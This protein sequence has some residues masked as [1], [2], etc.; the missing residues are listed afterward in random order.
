VEQQ[1]FYPHD[2]SAVL[3]VSA[4]LGDAGT[5]HAVIGL[6]DGV[7]TTTQDIEITV[8]PPCPVTLAGRIPGPGPLNVSVLGDVDGNGTLDLVAF[9]ESSLTGGMWP[10]LSDGTFGP[11]RPLTGSAVVQA[12]LSDLNGDGRQDLF[13]MSQGGWVAARLAAADGSFG[14]EIRVNQYLGGDYV[15]SFALEDIDEDG[16]MDVILRMPNPHRL[17]ALLG[18]GDGTFSVGPV[19]QLSGSLSPP[20]QSTMAL[21]DFNVDGHLDVAV[22][23]YQVVSVLLG[24]GSGAFSAPHD[25]PLGRDITSVAAGDMNGDGRADL[26]AARWDVAILLNDGAGGFHAP[27]VNPSA[28]STRNIR[29]GDV[30]GDGRLDVVAD[31]EQV[32]VFPGA[33]GDSLGLVSGSKFATLVEGL[34]L[35][36]LN[37]D[38][39]LDW[40]ARERYPNSNSTIEYLNL[41]CGASG[42][43]VVL[44]PH[45]WSGIETQLLRMEV[46][47]ADPDAT[48]ID[49]WEV[50]PILPGAMFVPSP[51]HRSAVFS[52][53]PATDQAGD[54]EVQFR[55]K[56]TLTGVASTRIHI[57][58]SDRPPVVEAPSAQVACAGATITFQVRASD[59]D[60]Q[61]IQELTASPL[62]PGATFSVSP[63]RSGGVFAWNTDASSVGTHPV[64]FRASNA[65]AGSSVCTIVVQTSCFI[66]FTYESPDTT[67][68][69]G[70]QTALAVDNFGYS[71]VVYAV[72]NKLRYAFR[73]GGLWGIE[74]VA[75]GVPAHSPSLALLGGMPWIA[76]ESLSGDQPVGVRVA[77]RSA[78]AAWPTETIPT[79]GAGGRPSIAFDPQGVPHVAFSDGFGAVR[80]ATRNGSAWTVE[81]VHSSYTAG[82]VQLVFDGAGVP[83]VVAATGEG[84]LHAVRGANGWVKDFHNAA[85][86]NLAL[87]IDGARVH[88]AAGSGTRLEHHVLEAG[89]WQIENVATLSGDLYSPGSTVSMQIDQLGRPMIAYH[90]EAAGTLNLTWKQG[91]SWK[92]QVVDAGKSGFSVSLALAGNAEP[93]LSYFDEAHGDLRYAFGPAPPSNQAP[94]AQ[95]GGPYE[96]TVG[97]LLTFDGSGSSDPDGD[98]LTFSWSYGDGLQGSGVHPQHAYA[99]GGAYSVSLAVDDGQLHS[100]ASTTATI[101]ALLEA[102]AF[103]TGTTRAVPLT[104]TAQPYL[105]VLVE[106]VNGGYRNEDLDLT[107]LVM[108][109]DSTGS[110]DEIHA[111]EGKTVRTGDRDRNGVAEIAVRFGRGDLAAL[112]A[113]V[114][115]RSEVTVSLEGTL[116]SGARVHA[117]LSLKVVETGSTQEAR[118][119]PNPLN[120][121]GTLAVATRHAGPL[122]ARLFDVSGRLVRILVRESWSP[123]GYRELTI[124]GNDLKGTPLASGVYFYRVKSADGMLTGRL[125][126]AR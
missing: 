59:P 14:P 98:A 41:G 55:A 125:T 101:R 83:H 57:A 17:Q 10:G 4:Q 52:W 114:Q 110:V 60:A 54:Y 123:A 97:Q 109:S 124:D 19:S 24:D 104:G 34:S 68:W 6:T 84:L 1:T 15:D 77:Y 43:P 30:T 73:A 12:S 85:G 13:F 35:G 56:N 117:P 119:F 5:A 51:D 92:S 46:S 16:R 115:G 81:T 23:T 18:H 33:A 26:V 3:K 49:T 113:N 67:G 102:R 29:L 86:G 8:V 76:F 91:G 36:D 47:A 95:A 11:M 63:D 121:S 44:A 120:P 48:P 82:S 2:F 93:R 122:D 42:A 118:V 50:A 71:H 39:R 100:S 58:D 65:L 80:Y 62:P 112:F 25:Y 7:N 88:V 105:T 79:V 116:M 22:G 27:R 108:R 64:T 94:I 9:V 90:D 53:T 87:A 21:A 69:V 107:S 99:A 38:G 72:G 74:D 78:P 70:N 106:P 126:I 28:A 89:V 32:L 40:V 37:K 61:P 111:Q 96:G 20:Y 45:E 103:M 66:P 75:R 31:G